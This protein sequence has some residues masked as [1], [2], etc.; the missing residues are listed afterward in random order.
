MK[1]ATAGQVAEYLL[2]EEEIETVGE[3]LVVL[4]GTATPVATVVVTKVE[5]WR[6]DK[7][8][9]SFLIVTVYFEGDN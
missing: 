2:E 7:L 9:D 8:P 6:F 4:D 5:V 1:K 3:R